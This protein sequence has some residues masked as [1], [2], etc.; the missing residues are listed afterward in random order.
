MLHPNMKS[1]SFLDNWINKSADQYISCF[2]PI[3]AAHVEITYI[4]T[5][6]FGFDI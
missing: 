5:T 2:F 4:S 3:W 1:L 6:I